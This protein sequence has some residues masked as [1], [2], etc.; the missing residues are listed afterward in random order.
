MH[1]KPVNLMRVRD[2]KQWLAPLRNTP[3]HPQWLLR[4]G[5]KA[6]DLQKIVGITVDIGCADQA[7]PRLLPEFAQYIEIDC[8][9]TAVS[10]CPSRPDVFADARPLPLADVSTDS[11][12]MLHVLVQLDCPVRALHE[13]V[14]MLRPDRR[15][16][17]EVR[18]IYPLHEA[19]LIWFLIPLTNILDCA[20]ALLQ[21]GSDFTPHRFRALCRKPG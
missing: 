11:A 18:F 8:H 7:I 10:W 2:I 9:G 3:L 6:R 5:R 21:T 17:I 14:R 13:T 19:P 16:M 1:L 15:L 12:L 20:P 4:E